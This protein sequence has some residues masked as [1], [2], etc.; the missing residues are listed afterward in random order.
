MGGAVWFALH[1]HVMLSPAQ[2]SEIESAM[3]ADLMPE[4]IF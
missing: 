4:K 3:D 2:I 1:A